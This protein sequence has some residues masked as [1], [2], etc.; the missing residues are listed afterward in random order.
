M[1]ALAIGAVD[2]G[3]L[4]RGFPLEDANAAWDFLGFV[5]VSLVETALAG[6]KGAT[7]MQ[8][9]NDLVLREAAAAVVAFLALTDQGV[10][11]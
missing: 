10:P 3:V 4:G 6:A 9:E 2:Q 8:A 11:V 7:S 1:T 5:N